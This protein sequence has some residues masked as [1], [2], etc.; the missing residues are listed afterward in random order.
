MAT[1]DSRRG[2]LAF[3]LAVFL[4]A[5]VVCSH[6][7]LIAHVVFA[8][9]TGTTQA[10]LAALLGALI[11]LPT[12]VL[13]GL[14][15]RWA[16]RQPKPW[17]LR[18]CGWL[19]LATCLCLTLCSY[20]GW[21]VGAF[22]LIPVLAA[23]AALFAPA[24]YAF[25]R[26]AFG[27]QRL[28]EVNGSVAAL[29]MAAVLGGAWLHFAAYATQVP[30]EA[31]DAGAVLRAFAPYTWLA[32][33]GAALE[34]LLLYRLPQLDGTA[35]TPP[36]ERHAWW[37][38]WRQGLTL[39]RQE[40]ALGIGT[41]GLALLWSVALVLVA[42]LPGQLREELGV[43]DAMARQTL[44]SCVGVGVVLG[45]LYAG[46]FSR[47]TLETSLLPLGALGLAT[48]LALLPG[49][50]A[51]W[52]A[53]LLLLLCGIAGGLCSVPL[54]AL[55]QY[56]ARTETL[57]GT[58]AA[59]RWLMAACALLSLLL[60]LALLLA[61]LSSRHLLQALALLSWIGALLLIH[62]W[63][64]SLTRV[65]L[66]RA[67]PLRCRIKVQGMAHI[68][69]Q[70]GVLLLGNHVSWID[71]AIVQIACPRPVRF[72]LLSSI[73]ELWYLKWFFKRFGCIPIEAG[74]ASRGALEDV[75]AAL[76]R[77]EVACLFPEG[78]ISRNG[79]LAQFRHG[80]ER[81]CAMVDDSVLIV[82]F[83]LRGLGGIA[84]SRA[85]PH[86][87]HRRQRPREVVVDFG[88]PLPRHTPADELKRNIIDLSNQSWQ[89]YADQLP[90]IGAHWIDACKRRGNPVVLRDMQGTALRA[91]T[92]LTASLLLARQMQ[93][94]SREQHSRD[95]HSPEQNVGLLLPSSSA[96]VLGN[97]ALW[98]LGKTVVNLNFTA[99]IPAQISALLQAEVGTV[100]TSALFLERLA[101]RG[102]DLSA[103]R[104]HCRF[105]TLE[106]LRGGISSARRLMM[107]VTCWLLPAS[108][109]KA[110]YL[111]KVDPF[112]CA[113]ILF[114]SGSEGHPKGV[115]LSH[116]NL[117]C[118]V[119]QFTELLRPQDDDVMLANLPPFH[120]FGLTVTHLMPLIERVPV[121]CHPDPTDAHGAALAIA[122]HRV[123]LLLGT[124]S[125]LRLYIR[126][127]K[128]HP[129]LLD[130][131]RLVVT[132]AEKLQEDVRREFKLKFNKDV[133]EGYGA[134]ETA[135]VAST[136]LP[137]RINPDN[138]KVQVGN[139]PG[140]VGLPLPGTSFRI[141]DPDTYAPLPTGES[142]MI[143]IS[144]AQVMHGYLKNEQQTQAALTGLD[145]LRWYVTGDK[146]YLDEDGFLFIQDRYSRFAKI[147]G[148]MVGMG[149]V[150]TALK[151]AVSEA[152][153]EVVVVNVPDVRKG[154]K[155]IALGN[156]AL[157]PTLLRERLAAEGLNP[158]TFPSHYF[159][160]AAIP[161][162][163]SGKVDF[164]GARALVLDL[165]A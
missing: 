1:L 39:L 94:H 127:P 68:P 91:R 137:D 71:W 41:G 12:I 4:N 119:K 129:L 27:K 120:A 88:A 118:N 82:P 139:K 9:H 5:W 125:F 70:G 53:A 55:V 161:R 142:G 22:V 47:N 7:L 50:Q 15:G 106:S 34:I 105:V 16:D 24:Q 77:G 132:G 3:Y 6:P 163:G 52:L 87:R 33:A 35:P 112:S 151:H 108:W 153:F 90:A 155:L 74:A 83:Y 135:P 62:L 65:L 110:L 78:V 29:A 49:V 79:H 98:T 148:E 104:E 156:R 44:L 99:P 37:T 100:Y 123:T 38:Q 73:Y 18:R 116:R 102:V 36:I 31:T 64:Q 143:L 89:E 67:L 107:L 72:V 21:F 58:L 115:L 81:A 76:T 96:S 133:L 48:A 122:E 136:N 92:A 42:A 84:D 109:L 32:V 40:R 11:L 138:W 146:G 45:A 8:L 158:L 56:F 114:S 86:P 164:A 128:V 130:S 113:A 140:S 57:G 20:R 101:S 69:A 17:V 26:E 75:A 95:K 134:T 85:A 23:Q 60:A 144:G 160:V 165:I 103:L 154:E 157:D 19:L 97:F 51:P 147:G 46:R 150:E 131:L 141:V 61:G 159:T 124:S 10:A 14:A 145:G 13:P 54:Q 59:S 93:R 25:I 111:R 162:L 149:T 80:Y 28:S 66:G 63:P 117:V 121:V 30:V 152:D 126:N 2:A 43:Q